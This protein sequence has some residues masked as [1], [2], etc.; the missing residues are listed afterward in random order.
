MNYGEETQPS[1]VR[2]LPYTR[3]LL[4]MRPRAQCARD[5]TLQGPWD[6][7]PFEFPTEQMA[8]MC[9]P[10]SRSV[11]HRTPSTSLTA[12]CPD[13][14]D[15]LNMLLSGAGCQVPNLPCL[16]AKTPKNNGTAWLT[17]MVYIAA[18]F[19]MDKDNGNK[20]PKI[21]YIIANKVFKHM[22]K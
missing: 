8:L 3:F 13:K 20:I 11:W 18:H 10:L 9:W 22:V 16:Y 5:L 2:P 19:L 4:S 6:I 14:R 1:R 7:T 21:G 12:P 15:F 17:G